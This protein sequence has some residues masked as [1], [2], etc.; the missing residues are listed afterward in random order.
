M[1]ELDPP[2][3]K[4]INSDSPGKSVAIIVGIHGNEKGP[5]LEWDWLNSLEIARGTLFLIFANPTACEQDERFMNVNLNR[6]F[7]K[8]HDEFPE[9]S[10]ARTIEIT[11]DSCD[12]ALDLH[13][14][15][16]PMD[17]PFAICNAR[18][19]DIAKRLPAKYIINI[20]D[21]IHGGGTDDYMA[22]NSKIGICFE[23]G[24]SER[25][26]EYSDTIRRGV[27]AF[28]ASQGIIDET[29]VT[30]ITSPKILLKDTTKFVASE[31]LKFTKEYSSFDEIHQGEVICLENRRS[32]TAPRDGYILFPRPN[33]PIGTEAFYTLIDAPQTS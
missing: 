10:L 6:R 18:S 16:E 5:Q 30:P 15:N 22:N 17:R 3:I 12:A 33:N 4:E 13:M 28:L 31:D 27:L 11:L 26:T 14:Y 2:I 9:D 20:P 23:T 24:S 21:E 29:I 25:P 7:G 1:I 19:N 8:G 32:I